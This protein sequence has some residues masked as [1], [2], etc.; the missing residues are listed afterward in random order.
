MHRRR[1]GAAAK[2]TSREAR[3]R[4]SKVTGEG[5]DGKVPLYVLEL[6]PYTLQL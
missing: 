4:Q 5:F 2:V 3:L 6:Y 1:T